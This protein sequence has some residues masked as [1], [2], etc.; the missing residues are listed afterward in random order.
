M[1]VPGF[2]NVTVTG[3]AGANND[4][5][6]WIDV[7]TG[8]PQSCTEAMLCGGAGA[9]RLICGFYDLTWT[10]TSVTFMYSPVVGY[11]CT[12]TGPR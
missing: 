3:V 1:G 11:T 6:S 12:A 2:G 7:M 10:P 9:G 8:T 5:V 4:V